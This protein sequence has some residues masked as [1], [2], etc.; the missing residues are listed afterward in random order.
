MLKIMLLRK[1]HEKMLADAAA[2]RAQLTTF[3]TNAADCIIGNDA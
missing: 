2:L 1:R 3:K